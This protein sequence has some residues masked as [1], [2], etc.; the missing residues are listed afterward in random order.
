MGK[1]RHIALS[2][3]DVAA[4]QKFFEEA[5]DMEKVGESASG[6]AYMSD[7]TINIALL[8]R[9]GRPLG[10][11]GDGLFYGID[12]FGVWVDDIEEARQKAEAAGATFVLGAPPS[13]AN[14]F[15]EIKYRDP[16]GNLFDLTTSGWKGAVKDVVPAPEK[17][18]AE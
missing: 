17:E 3:S 6:A 13:N 5:F 9:G 2:V 18:T 8:N 1:I 14:S 10:W 12:H 11:E 4:A 7:G 16:M 15:Y